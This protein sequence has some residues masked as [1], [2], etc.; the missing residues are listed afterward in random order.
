LFSHIHALQV[1][2]AWLRGIKSSLA[3]RHK[4]VMVGSLWAASAR[5]LPVT[6]PPL[7]RMVSHN[8]D[9]Y[10]VLLPK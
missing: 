6:F 9:H 5:L 3:A 1:R 10:G 4:T 8:Q 7:T 2:H